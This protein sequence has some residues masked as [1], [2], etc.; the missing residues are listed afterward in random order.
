MAKFDWW[1]L[2][3]AWR[4]FVQEVS[5]RCPVRK[6]ACDVESRSNCELGVWGGLENVLDVLD[7]L[8]RAFVVGWEPDGG[9]K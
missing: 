1:I 5:R 6:F 4:P 3:P 7:P 9:G 8:L 2:P